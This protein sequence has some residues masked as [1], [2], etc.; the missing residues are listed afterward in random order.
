MVSKSPHINDGRSRGWQ[1][2]LNALNQFTFFIVDQQKSGP[3]QPVGGIPVAHP[4]SLRGCI[5]VGLARNI[6][7][8][9]ARQAFTHISYWYSPKN[10]KKYNER[11]LKTTLAYYCKLLLQIIA[12]YSFL[13]LISQ[14]IRCNPADPV[15]GYL[16]YYKQS[17]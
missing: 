6:N 11:V 2:V 10:S 7:E 17:K 9:H 15:M 3:P 4:P 1:K 5:I 8:L 12:V 16:T 13:F 14:T